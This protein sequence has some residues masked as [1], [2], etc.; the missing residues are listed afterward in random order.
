[1]NLDNVLGQMATQLDT[2]ANLRVYDFPPDQVYPPC[3]IVSW[4][5]TYTYDFTYGRGSDRMSVPVVVLV[6]KVSDRA[7]RTNLAAYTDGSGASSVKAVLEAGTYTAFH[8]LRVESV[9]F[10]VVS[11]AGIDYAAALFTIDV[12]GTGA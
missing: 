2:I 1:M 5:D 6:G 7:S 12:V 3:A 4:P 10:D 8:E 11:V 9:D